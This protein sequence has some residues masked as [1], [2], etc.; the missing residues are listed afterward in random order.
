[1]Q[2]VP[3]S[4]IYRWYL[5]DTEL[6]EDVNELAEMIGLSRVSDEGDSKEREESE[7]RV[8]EIAPIYPYLEA[9][10]DVSAKSLVAMH[11]SAI[12]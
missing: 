4:T 5:Y 9:I 1:M 12:A 7:V 10:S 3:L 8:R 11:L 6:V 2:E